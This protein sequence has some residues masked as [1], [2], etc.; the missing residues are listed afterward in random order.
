MDLWQQG[1]FATLINDVKAKILGK[2]GSP[3]TT[4]D[5]ALA[6]AY[7]AKVLSGRLRS[8]VRFVTA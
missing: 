2:V 3:K 8:A 6:H 1:N 5:V 7:N 4:N